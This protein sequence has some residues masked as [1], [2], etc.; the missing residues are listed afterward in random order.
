MKAADYSATDTLRDGQKVEIRA[1]R[2]ADET[3]LLT[4]IGRTG[5]WSMYR[6]FFGAKRD[7]SPKEV[8]FYL[9]VDFIEHVALVAEVDEAAGLAIVGGGR[10]IVAKRGIAEIAF[11]V[12]DA[13]QGKGLG[14]TLFRHLATL[15]R[16]AGLDALVADVMP[17]NVA[18]LR[19][20]ERSGLPLKI[21]RS[22]PSVHV[23]ISLT[24]PL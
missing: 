9:N 11:I 23:V 24:P 8:A 2:P 5:D 20:F 10:Y 6:R 4:A 13:Y 14:T 12:I 21:T 7:F 15:A 18:M 19:V 17:E 3:G 16:E 22:G 1:L